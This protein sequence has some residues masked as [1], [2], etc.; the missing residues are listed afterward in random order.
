MPMRPIALLFATAATAAAAWPA[1]AAPVGV[2]Y[3]RA[4][5][6]EADR[7]CGLFDPTISAALNVGRLQARNAA[8]RAGAD[9]GSVE[10]RARLRA[11]ATPC[12][13]PDL[14]TV[15]ARVRSAHAGWSRLYRMTFPG[16][17]SAWRA[18]RTRSEG[19]R[20]RAAQSV[21]ATT[22]GL[23]GP[24][25]GAPAFYAVSRMPKRD[26]PAS[27]RLTV[28]RRTFLASARETAPKTLTTPGQGRAWAFR[29]PPGAADALAAASVRDT[30][31]LTILQ[32][33]STRTRV[34]PIEIGDF[35]AARAFVTP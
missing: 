28:G 22:V 6:A 19:P 21:G 1:A 18:D 27:A 15:A 14:A 5:I 33:N 2:L 11:A 10:R 3:E 12:R 25:P 4:L 9:P 34:V 13:S 26:V 17:R 31:E 20:W 8:A 30:A 16:P 35:A 7:R 23:A 32:S 29:F 24:N